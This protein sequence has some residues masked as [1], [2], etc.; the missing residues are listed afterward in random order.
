MQCKK[1][2]AGVTI[3]VRPGR[4]PEKDRTFTLHAN[5]DNKRAKAARGRALHRNFKC[6]KN[7]RTGRFT[8]CTPRRG[9]K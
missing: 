5:K 7:K 2:R 8:S 6:T 3:C 4:G 1:S 9:K